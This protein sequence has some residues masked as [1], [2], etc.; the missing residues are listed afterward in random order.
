MG[1]PKNVQP[2]SRVWCALE[3]RW[4]KIL[5]PAHKETHKE[6]EKTISTIKTSCVNYSLT[7]ENA[8]G[9][10][11]VSPR[12]SR[13]KL[14]LFSATGSRRFIFSSNRSSLS[15]SC[16][17]CFA[18]SS[19]LAFKSC[20]WQENILKLHVD[21]FGILT[22][23][24]QFQ[25]KRESQAAFM[26]YTIFVIGGQTGDSE[27]PASRKEL[28]IAGI[29][30]NNP[31]RWRETK[32]KINKSGMIYSK[33]RR[34]FTRYVCGRRDHLPKHTVSMKKKK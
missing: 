10:L 4:C 13:A 6:S 23:W 26:V 14:G 2:A 27:G 11:D 1:I 29:K 12:D 16:L 17:I 20:K 8:A 32:H 25:F 5:A 24:H 15:C 18:I 22:C 7:D 3:D 21:N 33:N 28:L 9:G 19:Y 34:S 30:Y 31:D